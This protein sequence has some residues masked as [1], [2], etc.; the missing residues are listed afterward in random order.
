MW[1]VVRDFAALDLHPERL[2]DVAMGDLF[3]DIMFRAFTT[4]GK[5][6]GAFYTPRDAIRLMVDVLFASD[7]EGLTGTA[8]ARSVYE[9]FHPSLIQKRGSYA[10]SA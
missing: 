2:P 8:S 3:E 1:Q 4:K 10:L 9:A 5:G 6:A 7:D